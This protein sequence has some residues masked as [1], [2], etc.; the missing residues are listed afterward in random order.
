MYTVALMTVLTGRFGNYV[1]DDYG[2]DIVDGDDDLGG[3]AA[4]LATTNASEK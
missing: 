4:V 1:Y 3:F 2:D